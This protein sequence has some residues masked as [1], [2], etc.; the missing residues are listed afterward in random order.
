MWK[1]IE[2]GTENKSENNFVILTVAGKYTPWLLC[3]ALPAPFQNKNPLTRKCREIIRDKET[4]CASEI[5]EFGRFM[6]LVRSPSWRAQEPMESTYY[7]NEKEM[8]RQ[9]RSK[10]LSFPLYI[11]WMCCALLTYTKYNKIADVKTECFL[12]NNMFKQNNLDAAFN[13]KDFV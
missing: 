12:L 8:S 10:N 1:I 9:K 6:P 5:F 7:T 3:T 11:G 2:K 13:L 4:F